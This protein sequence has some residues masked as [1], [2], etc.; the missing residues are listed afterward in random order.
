MEPTSIIAG[1]V[2]MVVMVVFFA[3]I[4]LFPFAT[5]IKCKSAGVPASPIELIA[6]GLRK[7]PTDQIVDAFIKASK[8]GLEVYMD[9]LEAHYLSGGNLDGVINALI[10]ANRAN[11]KLNFAHAAAIDLAGRDVFDAVQMQVHPRVISTGEVCG[12]AKN[13]IEVVVKVKI[14]VK[15]NLETMVGGAGEETIL[16]RVSEGIVS[17]IGSANTH[18]D[19]LKQP[20][21]LT[22][23]IMKSGLDAG[24]AFQIISLDIF[25]IDVGRNIGAIL[26]NDQAEA[27]KKVA[28]AKAE[29]R[30]ALA[31]AQ[32]QENKAIEQEAR[33]RLV[34]AE[35]KVPHALA[36][37]FRLGK[38][39]AARRSQ[40]PQGVLPPTDGPG[41]GPVSPALPG[42]PVSGAQ[43][44]ASAVEK[45]KEKKPNLGFGAD[46][47]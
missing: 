26:Q 32:L 21:L 16:A 47:G 2:L 14:T 19:V 5:F 31:L 36:G 43:E 44:S 27:D 39:I 18:T 22:Q 12:I 25:D 15:A 35:M 37:S 40:K 24:S 34:E 17:C 9:R 41:S 3:L 11:I 7:V 4:S 28:Q 6:M 42:S 45:E 10:S 20:E 23:H 13:G 29:G 46:L 38:L 1:V 30:R 8:A 33:A